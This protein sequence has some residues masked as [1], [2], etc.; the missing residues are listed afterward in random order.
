MITFEEME[1]MLDEIA[2]EL[3]KEIYTDLNGGISLVRRAKLHPESSDPQDLYILGEYYND[4]KGYGGLGRYI[5]IYY[6][7]FAA[8]YDHLSENQLRKKLKETLSHEFTH[9]L[10]SMAG[11][12]DLEITDARNL[13]RYKRRL[14]LRK[15]EEK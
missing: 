1:T 3:P 10:E 12:R 6:G 11:E 4:R 8:V 9:H 5:L 15:P 14:K 13:A 2:C 7:S